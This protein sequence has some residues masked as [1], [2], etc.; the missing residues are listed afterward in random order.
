MLELRV[1]APPSIRVSAL[2]VEARGRAWAWHALL[3]GAL[4][5]TGTRTKRQT[6]PLA[7]SDTTLRSNITQLAQFCSLKY[8]LGTGL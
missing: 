7:D 2:A 5:L 1:S 8:V 4:Q 3:S 6:P